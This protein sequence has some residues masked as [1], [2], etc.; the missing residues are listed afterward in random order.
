MLDAF[1]LEVFKSVVVGLESFV[2]VLSDAEVVV[3]EGEHEDRIC[4]PLVL[5]E[6]ETGKAV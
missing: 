2:E 6:V 1:N 5:D 3:D 4:S